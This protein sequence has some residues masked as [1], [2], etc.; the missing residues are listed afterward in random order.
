MMVMGLRLGHVGAGIEDSIDRVC[1]KGMESTASIQEMFTQV[2]GQ[3]DKAMVVGCRPA[4]MA[5]VMLAN[6]SGVS[7]TALVTT[8]SGTTSTQGLSL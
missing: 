1:V 8:T 6:S 5:V 4:V 3:M 2:I 7:S